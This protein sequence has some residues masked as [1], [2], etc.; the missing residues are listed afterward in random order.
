M[1]L[2]AASYFEVRLSETITDVFSEA[3]NHS[4]ALVEFVR[5]KAVARRYHDWFDW[6]RRNANRFF[7][8]FG[9][10]FKSF[11]EEQVNNSEEIQE[12]IRAFMELGDLRN[13]LAHQNFAS[14]PLEKTVLEIFDMYK[15][16]L[17]F[18]DAF[19][20]TLREYLNS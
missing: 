1:V 11:M 15:K 6:D 13:Q 16:A 3:T 7:S 19:P 9:S 12:S 8:A 2:S 20:D 17:G 10:G 14:F 18:V 4:D 5:S